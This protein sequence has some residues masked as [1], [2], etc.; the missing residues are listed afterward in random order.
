MDG[1]LGSKLVNIWYVHN[2][3]PTQSIKTNNN[4]VHRVNGIE[5]LYSWF[6]NFKLNNYLQ[7]GF[8][9]RIM[10]TYKTLYE[11]IITHILAPPC[12]K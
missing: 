4:Q 11:K 10:G 12:E 7:N 8:Q 5:E 2:K 9:T 1:Q 6:V 3:D